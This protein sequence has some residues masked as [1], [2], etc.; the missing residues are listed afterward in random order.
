MST[1]VHKMTAVVGADT[2][3]PG[4]IVHFD[5]QGGVSSSGLG[6]RRG[7]PTIWFEPGQQ[8]QRAQFFGTGHNIP[9]DYVH[10]GSC[11]DKDGGLVWHL[12]RYEPFKVSDL[13]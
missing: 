4:K 3:V 9:D 10:F 12:Y 1:T 13:L 2:L 5:V 11:V 6:L 8:T 7:T